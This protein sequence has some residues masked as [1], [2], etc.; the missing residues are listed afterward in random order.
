MGNRTAHLSRRSALGLA[1]GAALGASNPMSPTTARSTPTRGDWR[2]LADDLAGSVLRPGDSGYARFSRVKNTRFD[3]VR[4]AAVVRARGT[5]DVATAIRFARTFGLPVRPRSGGHSYTGASTADDALVIDVRR[6]RKVRYL[7]RS[8]EVRVGAGVTSGL[9]T[10][11]LA[12]RGRAVPL[13]TCPTVGVVGLALGGGLGIDSRKRGLT[14]DALTALTIVTADGEVRQVGPGSP[15]FW[16][17]R[18]GGGGSVGVVTEMRFR[19]HA[20]GSMGVFR[21]DFPWEYAADVV[22]GWADYVESAP[23]SVWCNLL[24]MVREDDT[25]T[26]RI[27]GRCPPG[28]QRRRAAD[29]EWAVGREASRVRTSRKSFLDAVDHVA[30]A[31]YERSPW[32]AGSDVIASMP[33]SLATTLPDVVEER[34]VAAGS[35][36]VILDP[37]TGAVRDRGPAATAFPW[38]RH[39]AELQWFAGVPVEATA[40]DVTAAEQWIGDAHRAV[41]AFSVGAY[42]NRI[43]SGRPS[44]DYY[45]GNLP[46]LQRI[47]ARRDPDGMFGSARTLSSS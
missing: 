22:T 21:V 36:M 41:R 20:A 5:S 33:R 37:L 4:P 46:R 17:A 1:G 9:L 26:V 28:Q 8:R 42:V 24:L 32:V 14:S 15:L 31:G 23:R 34:A 18:G 44:G 40:G 11:Q 27:L 16:A 39:L 10:R 6:L 12:E 19:T 13:G 29:V 25:R 2:T 47:T 38:R 3:D 43:E 7:G 35:S 45:A 30:G